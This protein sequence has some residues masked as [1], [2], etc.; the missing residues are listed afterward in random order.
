M[1]ASQGGVCG[2]ALH[3]PYAEREARGMGP[4]RGAH[5]IARHGAA[6]LVT[7]LL[8][9]SHPTPRFACVGVKFLEY[10]LAGIACGLVGQGVA[11]GLMLTK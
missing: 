11:N 10:S 9:N 6:L 7:L 1:R 4:I 5:G 3:P 8:R 2:V